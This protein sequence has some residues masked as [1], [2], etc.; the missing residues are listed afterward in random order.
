MLT[1]TLKN[2]PKPLHA[3]LKRLAEKNHRSLN[4]EILVRL[5]AALVAPMVDPEMHMKALR[6]LTA[7]LPRVEHR[8]IARYKRQ[9]RA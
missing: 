6:A 1:L 7:R 8:K 9:G 5:Q 4:S 3:R 2:I